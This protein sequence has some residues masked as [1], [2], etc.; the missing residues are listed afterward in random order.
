MSSLFRTSSLQLAMRQIKEP[1]R[2]IH[3]A[4]RG[5]MTNTDISLLGTHQGSNQ[6][7]EHRRGREKYRKFQ[8]REYISEQ[9]ENS[10]FSTWVPPFLHAC[11]LVI[12]QDTPDNVA[13]EHCPIYE[14]LMQCFG[15]Q[16]SALILNNHRTIFKGRA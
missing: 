10:K 5:F 13:E 3:E 7:M 2:G 16:L 11:L 4:R 9:L 6:S 15:R 12:R 14:T 8:Y 1:A